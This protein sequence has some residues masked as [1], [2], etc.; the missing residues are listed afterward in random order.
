MTGITWQLAHDSAVADGLVMQTQESINT[1]ERARADTIQ[2][3]L[4]TQSFR[5]TGDPARLQERDAAIR[6]REALMQQI[7]LHTADNEV[8][9]D[10]WDQLRD[11]LNQRLAIS[12][13]IEALRKSGNL[14]AANSIANSAPLQ[15]TRNQS[16]VLLAAMQQDER[17]VLDQ[18]LAQQTQANQRLAN[19]S[20]LA[21]LLLL[22]FLMVAYSTIR[23]Q[24]LNAEQHRHDLAHSQE[25]LAI[26]LRSIGDGVLATD[27][28]GRITHINPVAQHLT[29]WGEAEALGQPIDLV[30]HIV[31]EETRLPAEIP[32]ARVLATGEIHELANHTL[33]IARDGQEVPIADSA[34]PMRT[35]QGNV[36]GVV[37]VF[38][39]E[40]LA[41]QAKR[42]IQNQN[43][44][45]EQRVAERSKQLQ[46]S[47]HHLFHIINNL[48]ALIACVDA[49]RN[50]LYV[51]EQY[52]Q[53]FAPDI[54][55]LTGHAVRT[56][57]GET[58][59]QIA[60]PLISKAL[61]GEAQSYDWEPFPG[62]WQMIN[63]LPLTDVNGQVTGYYVLGTDISE[64][65]KIED[66]RRH[67]EEQLSR[68]LAGSDQGYW[69]WNMQTNAFQVSDRWQTMLGYAPGEIQV[70]VAHWPA[71]VHP[72]DLPKAQ[73]SIQAHLRGETPRHA[74]EIRCKTKQGDWR[75]ILTNGR[76]VSRADNGQPLMMSGTHT[77]ISER[78][79]LEA[80]Q[81][82]ASAVFEHS[83]QGIMVVNANG[84]IHRINPS[85]TRMTGY[86]IDEVRGKS[87][88]LLASGRHSIAFFQTFWSAL[89]QNDFWHGEIWNR[90]KSGE[91]YAALQS[92]TVVR[93]QNGRIQQ[94]VSLYTDI[95]QL[96]AHEVELE[97]A[98]NYD[99]LT[100]LPNRRLLSD[101]L[102]Q[103]FAR[104]LRSGKSSAVCFLD[105]DGF[106]EINDQYSHSVG[107]M[108]LV[109][110]SQ[111]LQG[112]LRSE[113][114]LARMGGD[115][116]VLLL[117]EV[118]STEEFA[119]VL[120]RVLLA[121]QQ[122]LEVAGHSLR[123]TASIGVS[124]Y[125]DDNAD[126]DTLL[127]HADQAMYLAK[128]AG[129]NRY[130]LFDATLDRVAQQHRA[131]LARVQRGFAQQE[132][133]LFY[134]PKVNLDT[135]EVIGM[136]ALI[137]WQHP[138]RGLLAPGEFVPQVTGSQL[139][140]PL[141]EWVIETALSQ[142][143]HWQAQGLR[144]RV[145]VNVS[146]NHLLLP[147]FTE[148]L[149]TALQ[150]H[151]QVLAS[152]FELEVLETAALADIEQAAAILHCCKA[153]G[154]HFSL[155]DFGTGYSSL[156][157]LRKLPVDTLKID[158]SFVRNMLT[159]PEDLGIVR[160]VIQLAAALH[161]EVIAEGVETL[162]LGQL[163]QQ[164]GCPYAQ[165]YGISRPMPADQVL[166][167]VGNWR[168][169]PTQLA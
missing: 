106:K 8:Q 164:M 5:I 35:P 157:Y 37:L 84:L 75:W 57:L 31:H 76:V 68:V 111:L 104:S 22:G 155:D 148:H 32:V 80:A 53:R 44:L 126:P 47:Q 162:E 3:E 135:R 125:P 49:E 144:L 39:D 91:I 27:I 58:R 141:G 69:D 72:D 161:R 136:E 2:V 130:Q 117:S 120:D 28:A 146:A 4:S 159:D 103:A 147:G 52:R 12:R 123:L 95:S 70:D 55:D 154:V 40:T 41:R 105:L 110:V 114:T 99:S 116:F 87:P 15:A 16:A 29:G 11:V 169:T 109:A 138:E 158:Q 64:R 153:L 73:A 17:S 81:L 93:D 45:L 14:R 36:S 65:H 34:S 66:A 101:R 85:F 112:A 149:E 128:Q 94:Y 9:H 56:V 19:F 88:K 26:T 78:K 167:W 119:M 89:K 165:G 59:Y 118:N 74:V 71:L 54:S 61:R 145:S 115:E 62:V 168:Q 82:E 97:H 143:D 127:R 132:F 43:Q 122:P 108:V 77:D 121:V 96:K 79:R 42:T 160:G 139:E 124:L 156:T 20:A 30:F 18:R 107:D 67:S 6:S 150:Q 48:P 134:Q 1:M 46:A 90:K 151:P 166:A 137:R 50:Y 92:V 152:N 142:I 133:V 13:Q 86:A 23:H 7:R 60:E 140:R 102:R 163:L 100:E 21:S 25:K 33:L 38:R 24:I 51:N 63:Y 129:K 113:D 98:A 83:Y 10:R 131:F